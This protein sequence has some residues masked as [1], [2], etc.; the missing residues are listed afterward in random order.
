LVSTD[1]ATSKGLVLDLEVVKVF[2]TKSF[3]PVFCPPN[4]QMATY[5]GLVEKDLNPVQ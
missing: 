4:R 2:A 3:Y 5:P 1:V